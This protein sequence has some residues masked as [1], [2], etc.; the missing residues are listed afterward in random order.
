VEKGILDPR[1]GLLEGPVLAAFIGHATDAEIRSK[2]QSGGVVSAILCHQ[3]ESGKI[4]R[5]LVTEMPADGSLHPYAHLAENRQQVLR[6]RGSQYSPVLY[7]S[8]LS[9]SIRGRK[10]VAMVGVPCQIQT[11]C[12]TR[13][14]S[15][16]EDRIVL[17]IGLFC[18]QILCHAAVDHLLET[19]HVP[20]REASSIRFKDRLHGNFPGDLR[21]DRRPSTS[22][23]LS[24]EVRLKIK[25]V[26]RPNRCR[27]CFD[28]L[29]VLAD[30]AVGD[31]WGLGSS[32]E[33]L[34]AI[35]VRTQRGL[36]ALRGAENAGAIA[37]KTVAPEAIIHGQ[38]IEQRRREWL[39]SV[40]AWKEMG[41]ITPKVPA[42]KIKSQPAESRQQLQRKM[43]ELKRADCL[44][45]QPSREAALA[46]ARRQLARQSVEEWLSGEKIRRFAAKLFYALKSRMQRREAGI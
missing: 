42:G 4:T 5:A 26:Y 43:R 32:K 11:M 44:A 33:G 28:K 7:D 29:N 19:A 38:G 40:D 31:T 9:L 41:R 3:L 1:S 12:N 8:Q 22:V 30:L 23:Y 35:L 17:S 34:S 45:A 10:G 36:D 24:N 15:T 20:R 13:K 6:A 27:L 39:R 46:E 16:T 14:N 25:S 2:A 21:I 37:V 18:D